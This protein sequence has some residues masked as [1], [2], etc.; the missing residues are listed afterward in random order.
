LFLAFD[1]PLTK[2]QEAAAGAGC[3]AMCDK[4]S[5]KHPQYKSPAACSEICQEKHC[6]TF[7]ARAYFVGRLR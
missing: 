4:W 7:A 2:N 6:L 3:V 1:A 5:V